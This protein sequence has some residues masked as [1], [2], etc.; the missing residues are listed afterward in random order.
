MY[1]S[2]VYKIYVHVDV[3]SFVLYCLVLILKSSSR[4]LL[5]LPHGVEISITL[6]QYLTRAFV[7][8]AATALV[9][10]RESAFP[11][12]GTYNILTALPV[13][14]SK[15]ERISLPFIVG[16]AVLLLLGIYPVCDALFPSVPLHLNLVALNLLMWLGSFTHFF[17]KFFSGFSG[18]VGG[19]GGGGLE[20]SWCSISKGIQPFVGQGAKG[21]A[22]LYPFQGRL[23][24]N[25]FW[26]GSSP[27]NCAQKF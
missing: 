2:T 9:T 20:P 22:I 7:V 21:W 14:G 27:S 19:E 17:N 5:W 24:G 23:L 6:A 26:F 11:P 13:V 18:G 12:N 3:W 1:T 4:A 15:A 16:F 25:K 10:L 8:L